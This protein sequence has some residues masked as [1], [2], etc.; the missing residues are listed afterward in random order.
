MTRYRCPACGTGR[1]HA[2]GCSESPDPSTMGDEATRD[3]YLAHET[4]ELIR[5]SQRVI[6]DVDRMLARTRR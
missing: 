5:K 3:P 1:W 6:A 2:V 4:A